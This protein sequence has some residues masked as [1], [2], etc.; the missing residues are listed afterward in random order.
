ML[1]PRRLWYWLTFVLTGCAATPPLPVDKPLLS[2]PPSIVALKDL[3]GAPLS[4]PLRPITGENAPRLALRASL[5]LGSSRRAAW[6]N[7]G[8]VVLDTALGLLRFDPLSR[9]FS[10]YRGPQPALDLLAVLPDDRL[11]LGDNRQQEQHELYIFD[12]ATNDSST[13]TIP[14]ATRIVAATEGAL[15]AL[16][17]SVMMQA[18]ANESPVNQNQ[19]LIVDGSGNE[20]LHLPERAPG[21]MAFAPDG[22][23]LALDT[24]DYA[25]SPPTI[26]VDV[27]DIEGGQVVQTLRGLQYVP[28]EMLFSAA[29]LLIREN[30][31]ATSLWDV[32]SG[33]RLRDLGTFQAIAVSADSQQFVGLDGNTLRRWEV[34]TARELAALPTSAEAAG[35][36]RSNGFVKLAFAPNGTQLLAHSAVGLAIWDLAAADAA[37]LVEF[38]S[39]PQRRLA[40]APDGSA[41]ASAGMADTQLWDL[42]SGTVRWRQ[43]AVSPAF[44]F[45]PDAATLLL[46]AREGEGDVLV[47]RNLDGEIVNTLNEGE[48]VSDFV[49]SP[50]GAAFATASA[51]VSLR[52]TE[53]GVVLRSLE[54]APTLSGSLSG[55]AGRTTPDF[56]ADATLLAVGVDEQ[57]RIFDA[58]TG[59]ELRRF[60]HRSTISRVQ[61]VRFSPDGALLASVTYDS[62]VLWD[63]AAGR[64]LRTLKFAESDRFFSRIAFSPDGTLLAAGTWL[65]GGAGNSGDLRVWEVASG[66]EL[67]A[68]SGHA[69]LISDVAF[70]LDGA[71]L[72][73]ASADGT[74]RLWGAE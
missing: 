63:V 18:N 29:G 71:L 9:A 32:A 52:D 20:I 61:Q 22:R 51:G 59:Q 30:G 6:F 56:S 65:N 67:V 10:D 36:L 46:T 11:L 19:L 17:T 4:S 35:V 28:D 26:A 68:L 73:S 31:G 14:P 34:A 41:L 53:S 7:D 21:V 44:A 40:F 15:L 33:Q 24:I 39:S 70:A 60:T 47:R 2:P 25:V 49:V 66:T 55:M 62:V 54:A 74:V 64:E 13:V 27:I 43:Q 12:F 48:A 37:P 57:A 50:T 16:D 42:A 23:L 38:F 72:A 1:R 69:D 58:A 5:G 45:A 8:T 3:A